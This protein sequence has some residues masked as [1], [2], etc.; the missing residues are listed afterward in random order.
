MALPPPNKVKVFTPGYQQGTG[1]EEKST[2]T[3]PPSW[4]WRHMGVAVVGP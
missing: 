3:S 4:E 2:S 1:G